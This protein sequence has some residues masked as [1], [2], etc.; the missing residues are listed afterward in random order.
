MVSSR[1]RDVS[2]IA[3]MTI[4]TGAWRTWGRCRKVLVFSVL[5]SAAPVLASMPGMPML[6]LAEQRFET[7]G[8]VIAPRQVVLSSE[9]NARVT[10]LP[11]RA[12]E[13]FNKDDRLLTF[14]CRVLEAQRDK[15]RAE[16]NAASQTVKS[17]RKM[18]KLRKVGKLELAISEAELAQARAGVRIAELAVERCRLAAP[19][20]GRV[21]RTMVRENEG[22]GERQ[23]LLEIVDDAVREMEVIVPAT[24]LTWIEKGTPLTAFID[25]TGLEVSGEVI[26]PGAVVDP[27]SQSM[28]LRVRL[29]TDSGQLVPGMSATVL[30]TVADTVP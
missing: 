27:A 5:L 28:T 29:D 22:V 19:F 4:R 8:V 10:R 6:S 30:F 23:E 16:R 3:Q 15:V 9:I 11:F 12:G 24:W 17:N 14:D 18:A 20:D 1:I 7:R 21:V 13:T 25:E 2:G 26:V